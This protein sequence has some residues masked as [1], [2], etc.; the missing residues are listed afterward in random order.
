MSYSFELTKEQEELKQMARDFARREIAPVAAE[1]DAK[2]E[3]PY[4]LWRKMG[5]EPYRFTGIFIP[6]EYDGKPR[7][8]TGTCII[9]EELAGAGKSPIAVMLVEAVG[10]GTGPVI[11]AGTEA[12][13]KKFLPPLKF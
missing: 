11:I 1:I 6:K 3:M 7:G 2:D 13:K 10:L 8:I 9:N 4:D 5:R 12:Q